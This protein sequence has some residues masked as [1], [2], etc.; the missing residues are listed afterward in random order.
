MIKVIWRIVVI[1]ALAGLVSGGIYLLVQNGQ[2]SGQTL[3]AL[4]GGDGGRQFN[5][6]QLNPSPGGDAFQA[7]VRPLTGAFRGDGA[8]GFNLDAG[9]A[10][11][12]RNLLIIAAIT[13]A[14]GA[15]R[16]LWSFVTQLARKRTAR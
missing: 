1:L 3:A 13:V 10:G 6:T 11:V 15:L 5:R 7:G 9:L 16:K 4:G 2:L 12:F 14:V 8:R